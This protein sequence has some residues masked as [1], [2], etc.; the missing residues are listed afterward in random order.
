[1]DWM[2]RAR[3]IVENGSVDHPDDLFYLVFSQFKG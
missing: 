2:E 3:T 1:M